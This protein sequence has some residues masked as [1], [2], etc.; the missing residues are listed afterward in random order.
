[1]V[2]NFYMLTPVNHADSGRELK[3][4]KG[5]L[6]RGNKVIPETFIAGR[7]GL[8]EVLIQKYGVSFI[9]SGILMFISL[10]VLIVGIGMRISYKNS[11]S[12]LYAALGACV[13]ALWLISNSYLYP[14]AFGHYHIDGIVNYLACMLL[15]FGFLLYI[16][17]VQKGRYNKVFN[18]LM[19][20]SLVSFILWTVLHF[21]GIFT[22]PYALAYIDAVLVVD[23]IGAFILVIIDIKNGY[24]KEY[25]YTVAGFLLFFAFGLGEIYVI[26][27]APTKNESIP[28]LVGILVLLGFVLWQ[29]VQDLSNLT[30]ERERAVQLSNA[31]TTF[32]A[33]MSHEIRTPI[34]SIL[35]MN[36]MIIRENHDRR[37][38]EYA[39]NIQTS[40]KMLLS[41]VNDVL[42]FSQLEAD[43]MKIMNEDVSLTS[44]LADISAMAKERAAGKDL[45]FATV[46]D[47]EV[48]DG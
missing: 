41:L 45:T 28:L 22:F 8:Y 3:I 20:I 19:M 33:N 4:F 17:S 38:D 40:G 30:Y 11:I 36:E 15:P 10:I 48:P 43:K 5:K 26:L 7:G 14:F 21:T 18:V 13:T 44:I 27:F 37:I 31:K 2:K 46:L 32:L 42:D 9:A 24:A 25:K 35:G 47:G 16:D 12:M 39:R 1:T 6:D 29:Q 23:I 34:N